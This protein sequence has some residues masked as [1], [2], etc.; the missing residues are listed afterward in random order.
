MAGHHGLKPGPHDQVVTLV[1]S[2]FQGLYC[3][4][5]ERAVNSERVREVNDKIEW[6]L[7][8]DMGIGE[9][10]YFSKPLWLL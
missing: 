1:L 5:Y 7:N 4:T 9:T 8:S 10:W 6:Q 2:R 3:E